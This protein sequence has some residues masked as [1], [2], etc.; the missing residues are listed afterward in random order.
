[1]AIRLCCR[2]LYSS[3]LYLRLA[4]YS[5]DGNVQRSNDGD[6]AEYWTENAVPACDSV[7]L[8]LFIAL[9]GR[10]LETEHANTPPQVVA[11]SET[12]SVSYTGTLSDDDWHA[13]KSFADEQASA[14]SDGETLSD[15]VD[16]QDDANTS[17][18]A[19]ESTPRSASNLHAVADGI[20]I[21]TESVGYEDSDL[22]QRNGASAD[23]TDIPLPP[24]SQLSNEIPQGTQ[25]SDL[26]TYD[27]VIDHPDIDNLRS[28]YEQFL[29]TLTGQTETPEDPTL[30]SSLFNLVNSATTAASQA[31]G[32]ADLAANV[33]RN[34]AGPFSRQAGQ[35]L[36][37]VARIALAQFLRSRQQRLQERLSRMVPA[38][39]SPTASTTSVFDTADTAS[40]ATTSPARPVGTP[41]PAR[42]RVPLTQP[43]VDLD[44][45]LADSTQQSFSTAQA[46][47]MPESM[48]EVVSSWHDC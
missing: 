16:V 28:A 13:V 35:E 12:M 29:H 45:P 22:D 2:L 27:D 11:N 4:C 44:A 38:Y 5:E 8:R 23:S 9:T 14:D 46:G 43:N 33:V 31:Y 10:L 47:V 1:M 18:E 36:G 21:A 39:P 37:S 19:N 17:S 48:P 24:S 40:R 26:P 7:P 34:H 30:T 20:R 41:L 6:V 3:L 25:D 15:L 42:Y 32:L